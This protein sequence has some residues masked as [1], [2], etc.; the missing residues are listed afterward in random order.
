MGQNFL[1]RPILAARQHIF[2]NNGKFNWQQ[3]WIQWVI[4][5]K[6]WNW[7]KNGELW[8]GFIDNWREGVEKDINKMNCRFMKFSKEKGV[9]VSSIRKAMCIVC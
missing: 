3:Y 2:K 1:K 4:I 5:N 7:M 8:K 6:T 9:L